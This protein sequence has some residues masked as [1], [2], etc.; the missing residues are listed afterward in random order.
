MLQGEIQGQCG[1]CLKGLTTE[2]PGIVVCTKCRALFHPE[3]WAFNGARC[4]IYGCS[5]IPP[6]AP[7]PPRAPCAYHPQ[8]RSTGN[9]V[10]CNAPL[11]GGCT[12]TSRNDNPAIARRFCDNCVPRKNCLMVLVLI[13]IAGGVLVF[14]LSQARLGR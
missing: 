8:I 12:W 11:C 3:C 6:K 7:E 9:C 14:V 4:G 10:Q 1:I 2:T 13:L 5:P